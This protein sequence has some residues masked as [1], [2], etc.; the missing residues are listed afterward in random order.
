MKV[1]SWIQS[2]MSQATKVRLPNLSVKKRFSLPEV[3]ITTVCKRSPPVLNTEQEISSGIPPVMVISPS[4]STFSEKRRPP[5]AKSVHVTRTEP[6][7]G[8]A[9]SSEQA[10]PCV[11]SASSQVQNSRTKVTVSIELPIEQTPDGTAIS[12][13]ETPNWLTQVVSAC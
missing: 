3:L 11:L 7:L 5:V 9:P 13:Q 4:D 8:R 12:S 2:S 10:P 1:N 6:S